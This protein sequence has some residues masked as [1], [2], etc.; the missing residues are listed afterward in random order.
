MIGR[1][2]RKGQSAIGEAFIIGKGSAPESKASCDNGE[3]KAVKKGGGDWDAICKLMVEPMP[4]LQSRL[5][6]SPSV[7]YDMAATIREDQSEDGQGPEQL[8]QAAN[9]I[10]T[11][12]SAAP[13][14]SSVSHRSASAGSNR[15][16]ISGGTGQVEVSSIPFFSD[17]ES[18]EELAF[19]Q[20]MLE[21][22]ANASATTDTAIRD[23]LS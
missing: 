17:N 19:Q 4:F 10:L 9:R 13:S 22:V 23:L 12:S 20:L 8:G 6:Q 3:V 7:S 5:L 2:G 11:R 15:Q 16:K 14:T 1:A 21:G 18:K